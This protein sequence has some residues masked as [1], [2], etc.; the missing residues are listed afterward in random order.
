M[1]NPEQFAILFAGSLFIGMLVLLEVGRRVGTHRL[2]QDPEGARTGIS[3]VEGSLFGLLGLLIAFTFSGANSRFEARR[4][5]IT[6]ETNNI[7]TAWLRMDL[8]PADA[9]P[10]LRELFR[11][12]LDSRLL[13]YKKL[14][15][16]EAAE[17]ELR[18]LDL[19]PGRDLGEGHRRREGRPPGPTGSACS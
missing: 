17:A 9:Q 15:D 14:P 1:R 2:A 3:A 12:Y 4:H 16:L 18:A 10:E 5:L 7:G 11:R 6:E 19:S 13:T 8:L